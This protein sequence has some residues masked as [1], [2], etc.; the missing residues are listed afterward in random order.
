MDRHDYEHHIVPLDHRIADLEQKLLRRP[1]IAIFRTEDTN[2]LPAYQTAEAAGFD[3]YAAAGASLRPGQRCLVSAGIKVALEP[4]WELQ[5]RPRSGLALKHGLTVLNSPG[6]IDSDYRGPVGV[7]LIN[8]S[9][10]T[11]HIQIGDRIGQ[12]VLCRAVQ[13][14]FREVMKEDELGQTARGE[15]GFGSTGK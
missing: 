10:D 1:T 11:V 5:V 7:L 4:G 12:A 6:T 2:P 15:H 13:A 3:L 9:T 8:E 14:D